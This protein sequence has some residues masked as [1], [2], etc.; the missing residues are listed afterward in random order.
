MTPIP[1]EDQHL[2]IIGKAR[3]GL[4]L[5]DE[6]LLARAGLTAADLAR[7]ESGDPDAP[8]LAKIAPVLGLGPVALA[9][10]ARKAWRPE[11]LALDGLA[12]FN[13]VFEDMTVN[14][15][16]VWDPASRDAVV[17]DT[18]ADVT[19]LLEFAAARGLAIRLV[20]LTHTH[21]D[22]VAD[23][24]RLLDRT[25]APAWV[26]ASEPIDGAAPFEAGR[27]FTV[28]AL[29]VETRLTSGHSPG[30]VTYPVHGLARP[31]AIVGDSVFAGSMGGG[32]VSYADAL[33]NNQR[34]ILTLPD[35]TILAPGHGP[36]TT[37]GEEKR[38][39]PFFAH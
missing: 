5:S 4:G 11:P 19:G 15:Y 13:T 36:L 17:F 27:S 7:L 38:H 21:E 24:P 35:E 26:H 2:D 34:H 1:L 29:R 6:I 10:A 39:N 37:V 23:L 31:L 22:H 12:Q 30:G 33:A 32:K 3:R 25:G 18:G 16:L 8:A 9:A 20:L 28:G 14:A